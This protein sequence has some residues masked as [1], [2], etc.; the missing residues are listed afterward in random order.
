MDRPRPRQS[1]VWWLEGFVKTLAGCERCD[2]KLGFGN[3]VLFRDAVV[4]EQ[5]LERIQRKELPGMFYPRYLSWSTS[6]PSRTL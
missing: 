4:K 5:I 1:L 3:A 6:Q 2:W